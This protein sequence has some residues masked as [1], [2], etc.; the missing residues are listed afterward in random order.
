MRDLQGSGA[1]LVGDF[2]GSIEEIPHCF[3]VDQSLA[4]RTI[5]PAQHIQWPEELEKHGVDEHDV[6]GGEAALAP[7]PHGED[8]CTGH[9]QIGDERLADVQPCER[10]LV[11]NRCACE[12]R[13][14]FVVPV[15]FSLFGTEIL[16]GFVVQQGIDGAADRLVVDL[17]HLPLQ[18]RAPLCHPPRERDVERH[19]PECRRDEASTEL[20]KEDDARGGQLDQRG[21]DIEE[22]KIE[23][24]VD[25]LGSPFHDL[26]Q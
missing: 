8:H 23:H 26:G 18:I 1:G 13:D 11:S 7:A 6:A 19:H 25:A 3:H 21:A 2:G 20:Y 22:K 14:R 24:H 16:D 4:D 5:D 10:Y 17:V 15:R 12:C 9:H